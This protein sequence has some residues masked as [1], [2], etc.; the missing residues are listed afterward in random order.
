LSKFCRTKLQQ[1]II[2]QLWM[3]FEDIQVLWNHIGPKK[4]LPVSSCWLWARFLKSN[5]FPATD[6][7]WP[8][9]HSSFE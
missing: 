2:L 8:K 5:F 1:N 3:K 7:V 9:L 4:V 6:K